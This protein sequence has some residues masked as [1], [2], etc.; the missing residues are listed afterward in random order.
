MCAERSLASCE[1]ATHPPEAKGHG[2]LGEAVPPDQGI[3]MVASL[4]HYLRPP[5]WVEVR[6][7]VRDSAPRGGRRLVLD[8]RRG[9]VIKR[10]A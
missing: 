4:E 2:R 7:L 3:P 9:V 8:K 6:S 1:R 10:T 5:V